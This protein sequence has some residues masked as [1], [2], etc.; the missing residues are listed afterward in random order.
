MA[1][2]SNSGEDRNNIFPFVPETDVI[3]GKD[4]KKYD[5]D[6]EKTCFPLTVFPNQK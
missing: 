6:V 1:W 4:R 2:P 3:D 5:M